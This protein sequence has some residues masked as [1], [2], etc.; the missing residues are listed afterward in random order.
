[1]YEE[2][3]LL[4]PSGLAEYNQPVK[5]PLELRRKCSGTHR[6]KEGKSASIVASNR[7]LSR[8]SRNATHAKP[9]ETPVACL[10]K[11][12]NCRVDC[13]RKIRE[14]HKLNNTM[15][16]S[17]K[18]Q[19]TYESRREL[20]QTGEGKVGRCRAAHKVAEEWEGCFRF[21][22]GGVSRG[23]RVGWRRDNPIAVPFFAL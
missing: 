6:G 5:R 15:A 11:P 3:V 14:R 23:V 4:A 17:K 2:S 19:G 12:H 1:V 16:D 10:H 7:T 13:N 20:L 22:D 9:T 21:S 18:N 8:V